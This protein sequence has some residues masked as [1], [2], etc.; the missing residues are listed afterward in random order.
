MDYDVIIVGGGAA[1]LTCAAYTARQGA[2]TALIEQQESFGGLIQSVS[3]NGFV[4]DMGLRAVEDA[5]IIKP[6]LAD[7]GLELPSAASPVSVG[8]EDRLM[9]IRSAESLKEYR[10]LL[11]SFYPESSED[12]AAIM[13]VIRTVMRRMEVLYGI[14]NPLFKDLKRDYPYIFKTL[15]PWSLKFLL[16]IGSINRMNGPV[17][18]FLDSLTG[19]GALKSIIGQHFFKQ[20][21]AFFA[22]S[23]FSVYMDY[24]YPLGGTASL[25]KLLEQFVKDR[26]TVMFPGR[27]ITRID[28]AARTVTDSSGTSDGYRELVWCGDLKGL[29]ATV[30]TEALTDRN[31]REGVIGRGE[32]LAGYRGGDSVFSL[33]LSVDERPEWFRSRCEGH[34]F[35]TPDSRGLGTLHTSGLR[36]LLSRCLSYQKSRQEIAAFLTEYTART[37]YEISIPVLKDPALAPEGKT[38][39]IISCLFDYDL[40]RLVSDGGGLADFRSACRSRIVEVLSG[41]VFPGLKEKIIDSF[42]STPLSIERITGNSDGAI[43]GWSF[44]KRPLPVPVKMQE[45][46]K[47]VRTP[48]PHVSKAGQWVFSPSGLPISILTGK[49]AADRVLGELKR[50]SAR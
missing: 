36:E 27:K 12:I 5:G 33:F 29:Y 30:D 24:F 45:V 41:T 42:D 3:K 14:E 25:M 7:L 18:T 32:E 28:P 40:L 9:T 1:G 38:G 4:F 13:K 35:Y 16:T 47:A 39:L 37:T 50:R 49:L 23:Y 26:G 17:E 44:E 22:M 8:I 34:F 2:K 31:V 19:N 15:L 48:I 20:T 46:A 11:Q 21:P 6:M 10:E 43:T